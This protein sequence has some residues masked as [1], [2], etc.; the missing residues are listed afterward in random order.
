MQNIKSYVGKT[1]RTTAV[2]HR[3]HMRYIKTNKPV[4]EYALHILDNRHEYD[5]P[6]H[7]IQ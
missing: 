5:S 3:E 1:G 7:T 4:S 2:R 6:E